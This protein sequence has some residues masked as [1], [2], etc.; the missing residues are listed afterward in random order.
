[1]IGLKGSVQKVGSLLRHNFKTLAG[2]LVDQEKPVTFH[3]L[4]HTYATTLMSAG[5]SIVAIMKLLGHRRIA[6]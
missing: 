6:M 3:R 1:M 2:D 4:R 5:V